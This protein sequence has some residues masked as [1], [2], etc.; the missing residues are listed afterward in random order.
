MEIHASKVVYALFIFCLQS[1]LLSNREQEKGAGEE[2]T[3]INYF[4]PVTYVRSVSL[5]YFSPVTCVRSVSLLQH[6]KFLGIPSR[7][8]LLL[9]SGLAMPWRHCSTSFE[10]VRNNDALHLNCAQK[11]INYSNNFPSTKN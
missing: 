1:I 6:T 11:I 10:C 4:S 7:P 5:N 2:W 3:M 9:L 8:L